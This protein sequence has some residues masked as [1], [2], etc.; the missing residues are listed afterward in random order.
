MVASQ[1]YATLVALKLLEY[2]IMALAPEIFSFKKLPDFKSEVVY[3]CFAFVIARS[4]PLFGRVFLRTILRQGNFCVTH[5]VFYRRVLIGIL[6]RPRF[7]VVCVTSCT[8][9]L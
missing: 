3:L 8:N 1:K 7:V 2:M 6:W 4:M 5:V 9:M